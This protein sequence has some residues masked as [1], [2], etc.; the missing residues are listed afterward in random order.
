M[1]VSLVNK[2]A[3]ELVAVFVVCYAV[4]MNKMPSIGSE[5]EKQTPV[6]TQR[7]ATPDDFEFARKTHHEGYRNVVE[8]QFGNWDEK[9]QDEFFAA[10]WAAS[11]HEILFCDNEPCGYLSTEE[12][13]DA[14]E[15]HELVLLPP[16]QGR[17]I[18]QKLLQKA[19][20]T[21]KE[22]GKS[23][24]LQVLKEN[25]AAELYRRLGFKE[26]GETDTHLKME[27]NPSNQAIL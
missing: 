1:R 23:A 11:P 5:Q 22:T 21:A 3:L 13:P 24:R 14:V 18:G 4:R 27:Y 20:D 6:I 17:G 26:V 12:T 10:A 15:L 8:K 2:I 16:F 9:R 19:I 7:P 25:L